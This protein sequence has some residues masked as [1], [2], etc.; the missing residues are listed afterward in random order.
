MGNSS[1]GI[2]VYPCDLLLALNLRHMF[3]DF[4]NSRI[5][6]AA[7]LCKNRDSCNLS[8]ANMV[9]QVDFHVVSGLP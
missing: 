1:P 3:P 2:N 4:L 6:K 5:R 7:R 8:I 9:H